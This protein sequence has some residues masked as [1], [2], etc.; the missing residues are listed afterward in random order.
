MKDNYYQEHPD[1]KHRRLIKRNVVTNITLDTNDI[2]TINDV[3]S[4]R[5]N[6]LKNYCRIYLKEVGP[7]V[8]NHSREQVDIL[9]K[10]KLN[11]IGFKQRKG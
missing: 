9:K 6:I 5:G 1:G 11:Q 3:L 4:N 2:V 8:V 7:I 10:T